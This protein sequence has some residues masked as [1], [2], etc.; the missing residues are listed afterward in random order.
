MIGAVLTKLYD[1]VNADLAELLLV[2]LIETA[3]LLFLAAQVN[4]HVEAVPDLP[5]L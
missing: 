3:F 1:Q 2:Y 5:T 4:A